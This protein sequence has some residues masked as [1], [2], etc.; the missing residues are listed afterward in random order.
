MFI[1]H[2]KIHI[3]A[4]DG[5]NGCNSFRREKYVPK[6]GPDGGDG[7]K[8]GDVILKADDN[9]TSLLDFYYRPKLVAK[10]GKHGK[11]A[12]K[13]GESASDLI[14]YVPVGTI[15]RDV[16]QDIVIDDLDVLGKVCCIGHGGRGGRGNARFATSINRAPR[17]HE[18]G[19]PGDEKDIL[20]ELRLIADVGIVG[21]P[22]AGKSTFISTISN[23]KPKIASYPFTTLAPV[24]GVVSVMG[25]EE[26]I[27]ADMPGLVEGAHQ[28]VGLGHEFLRHIQRTKCLL[29]MV[30]VSEIAFPQPVKAYE[31]LI[32]ELG[33]YDEK[34]LMKPRIV[35]ASKVELPGADE[36]IRA[37]KEVSNCPVMPV[38]SITKFGIT[39]ILTSLFKVV[40]TFENSL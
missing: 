17:R 20:L 33:K 29:L 27:F 12:T 5:G 39:D 36:N 21:F 22:N 28:N 19:F 1:D 25:D 40:K 10:N 26:L 37:L 2:I 34:L 31:A 35:A 9:L 15:I 13:T 4:G 8:G 7:G 14:V 11:G 3:K 32:D 38:S 6:G 30:D 18:K 16:E 23:A 24:L